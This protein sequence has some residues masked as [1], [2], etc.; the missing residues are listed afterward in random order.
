MSESLRI[1]NSISSAEW[2]FF[3]DWTL[4]SLRNSFS[5]NLSRTNY[6][7]FQKFFQT[8]R[9][10]FHFTRKLFPAINY[11]TN[12][13][14]QSFLA[15]KFKI[16]SAE[17]VLQMKFCESFAWLNYFLRE[18]L[19]VESW[20]LKSF[21][22]ELFLPTRKFEVEKVSAVDDW[23]RYFPTEIWVS[24][25]ESFCES[26]SRRRWKVFSFVRESDNLFCTFI[27]FS[28]FNFQLSLNFAKKT[29]PPHEKFSYT[30]SSGRNISIGS[31]KNKSW[32]SWKFIFAT[33]VA[34]EF[35]N[36]WANSLWKLSWLNYFYQ[37]SAR[38]SEVFAKINNWEK[39][40]RCTKTSSAIRNLHKLWNFRN[41]FEKVKWKWTN[42]LR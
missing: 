17:K 19:R 1:L 2:N 33:S 18:I 12:F 24:E 37:L 41:C 9:G 14:W 26:F 3:H 6:F 4:F 42:L 34:S 36:I 22:T 10:N 35:W 7:E 20:K 21:V 32:K 16:V 29:W 28:T 5:R 38:L 40:S 23:N 15:T 27:N 8:R 11:F 31:D 25:V 30:K 39:Y 13:S